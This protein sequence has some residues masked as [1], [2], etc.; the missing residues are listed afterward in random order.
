M[1]K[2]EEIPKCGNC[3]EF[4]DKC[5]CWD[6]ADN[7]H[8]VISW[9]IKHGYIKSDLLDSLI[10]SNEPSAANC[11]KHGRM[12][13]AV[14]DVDTDKERKFCIDCIE[15]LEG[16]AEDAPNCDDCDERRGDPPDSSWR[17]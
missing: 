5:T 3:E 2:V 12:I 7:G 16:I 4:A 10:E 9:R 17:D 11:E 8:L 14:L 1:V 13:V 6:N 15:E